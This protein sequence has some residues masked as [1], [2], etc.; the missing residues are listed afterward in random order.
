MFVGHYG[1]GFAA[2][3]VEPSIP[4]WLLFLA[5]QFLDVLWAPFVLLGIEKVRIV[6]GFT[7]TNPLDLYYMPFTH[8]LVAAILW[9]CA[10]GLAYQILARPSRRQAG[11]V[12][13]V[14]VFSHWVLDFIVHRPDL[15]LY[16]NSAKVGLGL[17]ALRRH[18]ALP[19]RESRPLGRDGGVRNPNARD[20]GL[21]LLR[22]APALGSGRGI[23]RSHRVRRL[24]GRGVV[25]SGSP[26]DHGSRLTP[27]R[28]TLR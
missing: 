27:R 9:S 18:L 26:S 20:P 25:A 14:A 13:G 1:V 11:V 22:S 2:K 12:I 28:G 3:R 15:P 24:R 16:D 7:A 23:D 8:G 5:V 4:L 21:C 6:P 19:T 10:G 17:S